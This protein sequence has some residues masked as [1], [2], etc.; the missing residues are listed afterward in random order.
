MQRQWNWLGGCGG[1]W[2]L[3]PVA[4]L[5]ID[6][7]ISFRIVRNGRAV[8]IE[9]KRTRRPCSHLAEKRDFRH[10]AADIEIAIGRRAVL[11]A[12]QP[13]LVMTD[14]PMQYLRRWLVV[15]KFAFR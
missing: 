8:R 5:W 14:G 6:P 1:S 2:Q 15:S 7:G 12:F 9:L 11:A 10:T 4:V 3:P 13:F